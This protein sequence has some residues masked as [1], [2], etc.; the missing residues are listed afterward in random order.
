[1]ASNFLHYELR[2]KIGEGGMGVV[3]LAQDTRL[4][5]KVAL[6]FLPKQISKDQSKHDRFRV[7]AQAAAGLNHRNIA[8]VFAI[9]EAN[10]ELCIVLEYVEGKELKDVIDGN[11]LT[12]DEKV[13]ISADI[14]EGIKAA[15]QKGIVHRDIKSRNIMVDSSNG[16]KIMDFG[17]AQLEG[18]D[19][20]KSSNTTAGTTAYM[21]PEQLRGEE[22]DARSDIWSYGVVLYELFTGKLPFQGMHEA[23]IMYSITEED[24]LPIDSESS[25][26]PEYIR[27]IINRCLQKNPEERY[28][29][30]SGVLNDIKEGQKAAE[31]ST[32]VV[33]RASSKRNIYL[34]IGAAVFTILLT[35]FIFWWENDF[36]LMGNVP[37]KK[38]MAVLPIEN[39][40]ED[41][42][43]TYISAGLTETL[44]YRLSDLEQYEDEYW[45]TPASEIRSRNVKSASEANEQFGVNIAIRSTIQS[46]QDSTRL[47]LD[48]IDAENIVSI[49]TTQVTVHSNNLA[50]LEKKSI[51]AMLNMLRIEVQPVMIET[52]SRGEP[53]NPE[54]YE[55]YLKGRANLHEP[56]NLDKLDSAIQ[57]FENALNIDPNFALA[58]AGTGEAY[59]RK[60]VITQNVD[61]VNQAKD[62]LEEAQSI[63]KNLPAVQFL[64]G[65]IENGQNNY[66]TAI[67][68]FEN[69]LNLNPE[70]TRA[71]R[72]MA[73]AYYNLGEKEEALKIYERI[74]EKEPDFWIGYN[75][76]AL[77]HLDEGNWDQAIDNFKKA[78]NLTSQNSSLYSNLGAVYFWQNKVD[79]AKIMFERSM[80][81]EKNPLSAVNLATIYYRNENYTE[82][83]DMYELVLENESFRNRYEIWAN[84]ASAV[85][86]SENMDGEEELYYTAIEKAEQ[87]LEVNPKDV[88][89][90]SSIAAFHADLKNRDQALKYIN[91]AID[92]NSKDQVF[93]VNAISTYENLG[94]REEALSWVRPEIISQ[95]EWIP[96]LKSMVEDPEYINLKE[97]LLNQE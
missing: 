8:Q 60:F 27:Q 78:I 5:R 12:T 3:Y 37:A 18:S 22:A 38:H 26:I 56:V 17:L 64:M 74:I 90:L 24:P 79:S 85:E 36:V 21:S 30:L 28:Q 10:G 16:V 97:E 25:E 4:N 23:A 70:Y 92:L 1:M 66:E 47:I 2:K 94:M 83:A 63:D 19:Q 32:K 31:K 11:D 75:E 40:S 39:I 88:V 72:I 35:F 82:A 89:V 93:I 9:E 42:D 20:P 46:I 33:D 58:H 96:D 14:A 6:K 68:H 95:I 73:R 91:Q 84:Y 80:A 50:Q 43:L 55:H 48:L 69:A 61:L 44:S 77:Y 65:L 87:Q 29:A 34:V 59:W 86:W 45:V 67:Q 57:H 54:A 13:E 15:H 53:N 81:I 76:L 52:I 71:H 49:E 7:E 41:P 51:Q 62:A